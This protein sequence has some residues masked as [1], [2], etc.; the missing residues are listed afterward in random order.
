MSCL[1]VSVVVE[2]VDSASAAAAG[3]DRVFPFSIS[4]VSISM[5]CQTLHLQ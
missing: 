1:K 3:D 2:C 4:L 5:F